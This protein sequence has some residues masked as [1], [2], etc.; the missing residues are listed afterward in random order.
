M[1]ISRKARI[2]RRE[3]RGLAAVEFALILPVMLTMLFGM[4]ELSMALFARS[5]ITQITSTVADL[6]AQN[7]TMTSSDFQNVYNAGNT[8]LYPYYKGTGGNKPAIR[9]ISVNFNAASGDPGYIGT[10]NWICTQTG[11]GTF[12]AAAPAQNSAYNLRNG[13]N[14]G[15][16]TPML[17]TGGSVIV[18]EV[19]YGYSSP[20]TRTIAGLIN[21]TD[22]F[23]T[24]PR[25]VGQIPRPASC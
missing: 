12:A 3:E 4:G 7:S 16:T 23:Y 21:M 1:L 15:A 2:F 5:D 17:S 24:K 14:S 10:V 22:K 20:T 6:V 9:I 25:R 18:A 13:S 11:S 19:A 8:I